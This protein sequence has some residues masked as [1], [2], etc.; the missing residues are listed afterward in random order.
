M[1]KV[2]LLATDYCLLTTVYC[3][4]TRRAIWH[5]T[6]LPFSTDNSEENEDGRR[7]CERCRREG[8]E[9]VQEPALHLPRR[10]GREVLQR[11]LP[12]HRAQR[13]DRLR[14]R[15][16]HLQGRLLKAEVGGRRSEVSS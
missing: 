1:K 8:Q 16:R 5:R 4:L 14:L 9:R 2:F 13:P 3:F 10:E 7:D 11:P 6:D 12:E 15:P